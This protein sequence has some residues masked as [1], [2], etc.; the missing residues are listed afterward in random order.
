MQVVVPAE[1]SREKT[2]ARLSRTLWNISAAA[3]R[4]IYLGSSAVGWVRNDLDVW[5]IVDKPDPTLK[6]QIRAPAWSNSYANNSRRRSLFSTRT[7]RLYIY[8]T[9]TG[10][11]KWYFS[12]SVGT[13]SA[14][15]RIGTSDGV[16]YWGYLTQFSATTSTQRFDV[17]ASVREFLV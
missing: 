8:A 12:F 9:H 1:Q 13:R 3:K 16:L 6:S 4:E 15:T 2:C 14:V 10:E 11:L 17:K 5:R 7:V